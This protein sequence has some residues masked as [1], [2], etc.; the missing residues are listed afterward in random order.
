MGDTIHL[1]LRRSIEKLVDDDNNSDESANHD[2][3]I[4]DM[5]TDSRIK[6]VEEVVQRDGSFVFQDDCIVTSESAPQ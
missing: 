4:V 2:S 6:L 1:A 3:I 5:N